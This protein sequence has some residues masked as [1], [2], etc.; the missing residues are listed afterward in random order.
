MNTSK[1]YSPWSL[2]YNRP[3][4]VWEE[5][6]P[7][8]NGR[9][10]G[11]VFGGAFNDRIQLNEDTLWSGRPQQDIPASDP[12]ELNTVRQ[13][14]LD[15]QLDEA[16]EQIN[17]RMLGKDVEAYQPLGDLEIEYISPEGELSDY[18]R[19]LDIREAIAR[20][21][22]TTN[23][24][25][26][27]REVLVSRPHQVM[28]YRMGS[29]DGTPFSAVI[30]LRSIQPHQLYLESQE[31]RMHGYVYP[32]MEKYEVEP[33]VIH[34]RE[35]V[36]LEC[37]Q[38]GFDAAYA[39]D[40]PDL[41]RYRDG[42]KSYPYREEE[43]QGIHFQVHARVQLSGGQL[44]IRDGQLYVKD[45]A[46]L[47]VLL[48]AVTDFDG[49][50]RQP[51][52][53]GRHLD[54]ECAERLQEAAAYSWAELT[55]AHQQ[56]HQQLFDRVELELYSSLAE[57]HRAEDKSTRQRV[58]LP[59][60]ERLEQ[61]RQGSIDPQLEALYFHYGRYLLIA[62]SRPGDQAAN[63]QGIW[64]PHVQPPWNSDYTTNIN[65]QMNYWP[66][67][68]CGLGECHQPLFD[69]IEEL[70]HTG[71]QVAQQRYGAS[72]WT[73]HHNTDLWRSALPTGGDASWAFWPMGG[74]W[75]C[76]HLWEHYA[77]TGNMEFLRETG[78]PVMREAARFALDWLVEDRQGYLI[79]VPSTSPENKFKTSSGQP[80]STSAAS[81]MD[82]TLIRELFM[83]C[84]EASALLGS[85]EELAAQL[86][87]AANRLYPFHIG[88]HGQ[89]QEWYE[90]YEEYEPG[91]RHVSH[92]YGLYPGRE[93]NRYETPEL[94]EAARI[95]L[96]RRIAHGGGHTGWS[97]AWL[98]N[99]YS[100]LLD[101]E[102]AYHFVHTLLAR[103]TYPN[104]FD[105]HPPFQIDGN[106]GGTAGIAEM[107]LQSHLNE[108]HLLPA[109]PKTWS[110]GKVTGL[111]ARGGYTVDL[112]WQE[113]ELVSAIIV[114]DNDTVCSILSPT[115]LMLSEHSPVS[116]TLKEKAIFSTQTQITP[117]K[118]T[119]AK[120]SDEHRLEL[121]MKAGQRYTL[122]VQ[123]L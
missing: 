98:I 72:G 31:L 117:A 26:M 110:N 111:R 50:D 54:E 83:H 89:L 85:D 86:Q 107:L 27:Q 114:S 75:L 60:D 1:Q 102:Q 18:Y 42:Y 30:R 17:T 29:M 81:T 94:V 68:V 8:G 55:A 67:E 33:D 4:S 73:A 121:P 97:C 12:G 96:E 57:Q 59:T 91:H 87:E 74:V 115:A 80:C 45:T 112:N 62:C 20:T 116:A 63:L 104:L 61:Y 16:Q 78:Y 19:E 44:E 66:A 24:Q 119:V 10:G 22:W 58:E 41:K 6:L 92:L 69:L 105:A 95:S 52:S 64:N 25:P 109:L 40:A 108:L 3:A 15:G 113:G 106:F 123:I 14:I 90:D 2:W 23:G 39:D 49:Y 7:I 100:R 56:D 84:I 38:A 37:D 103:S 65:V 122:E 21:Y 47:I 93:I 13:L 99:L 53:V 77:F 51:G 88:Q 34:Y 48:A 101:G 70:S 71:R 46:E 9:L 5:A 120:H 79:T 35:G 118:S 11:M 43:Q 32:D 36:E 28:A 76:A 82:M